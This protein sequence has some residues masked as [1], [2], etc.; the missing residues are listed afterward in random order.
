MLPYRPCVGIMLVNKDQKVFVAKRI[1]TH[2]D[3]WQMPQGGVGNGE[4]PE[5][6]ALRELEEEIGT[7]KVQIVARAKR[8]YAYDLP[9]GL[10][11]RFWNGQYRGQRQIWYLMKF[12]GTDRDINV[13]TSS[14][15]F[16]QWKWVDLEDVIKVVVHFKRRLYKAVVREFSPII[17]TNG[18][19]KK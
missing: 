13:A 3:A 11:G 18:Y 16:S 15:E 19:F 7:N 12:E 9:S 17:Q 4:S 8:K 10:L 14:P 5:V 2:S 6:A 1:E